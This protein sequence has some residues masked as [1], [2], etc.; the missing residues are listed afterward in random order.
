MG[1]R[2]AQLKKVFVFSLLCLSSLFLLATTNVYATEGGGGAYPNGAEDFMSGAV[3]PPGYYFLNYFMYYHADQ[4]KDSNGNNAIPDFDLKVTADVLRFLYVTKQQ[5]FGGYWGVHIFVPVVHMDV[6]VPGASDNTTGIGDIIVDPFILS[7]HFKNWH[8]ATGVDVYIPVSDFDKTQIANVSRHYWTFEPIFAVTY[9]SD[10]GF[11]V[12]SKFMYDFN[13][14][15]DDT[16]YQ[17]GQEFH[18]DYTIGYKISNWRAGLGGYYYK[19]VT[20]DELNGNKF[21][22]GFKGQAFALGPQVQ[23]QYK[24][25]FF[26]LK[27]LFETEVENKPEGQNLWFKFVYA[28]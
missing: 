28:F 13:T 23:Y 17:S 3:P 25:M 16:D 6:D 10:G 22:D 14:E 12:S 11:E 21:I 20:N 27:Y 7:W 24:N 2:V 26:T 5:I 9:M 4:F 18:F 1:K 15:N 8:L 19:Q